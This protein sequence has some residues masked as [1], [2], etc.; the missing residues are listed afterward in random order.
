MQFSQFLVTGFTMGA[1]FALVAIGY[2]VIFSATGVINFAQ[3]EFLMVGG[4]TAAVLWA[5]GVPLAGA[6]VLACLAVAAIGALTVF[7]VVGPAQRAGHIGTTVATVGLAIFLQGAAKLAFGSANRQLPSFSDGAPVQFAGAVVPT[8][9]LWIAITA[10]LSFL[11]IAAFLKS[12]MAGRAM[13]A[14]ADNALASAIV[15]V[16]ATTVQMQAYIVGAVLAGV[17]GVL[18]APIVFASPSMGTLLGL[19]GFVAAAIGG[20]GSFRG[21]VVGGLLVGV[22]EA[23]TAAYVSTAYRDAITFLVLILVLLRWPRGILGAA[24]VQRV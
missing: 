11:C 10:L 15:G 4:M 23:I 19:K 2:G 14:F 9:N 6:V 17:A 20:L 18:L 21:A 12:T 3:G 1:I 22:L 7:A 13:L 8:Q 24:S 16:R 5:Q